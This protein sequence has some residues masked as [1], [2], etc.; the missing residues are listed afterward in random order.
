MKYDFDINSIVLGPSCSG[1]STFISNFIKNYDIN[2]TIGVDLYK[3]QL[4]HNHDFYKL[5]IWDTGK[6]LLYKNI[7]YKFLYLSNIYIIINKNQDY[8]FIKKIFDIANNN[9]KKTLEHIIIIYNKI[10]NKDTFKYNETIIKNFNNNNKIK[11]Y[12][13]YLN[14]SHKNEANKVIDNIKEYIEY[15]KYNNFDSDDDEESKLCC[16]IC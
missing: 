11:I 9:I 8:D 14:L 3:L 1:K 13:L 7:I 6:G 12:F 5:N 15:K 4:N 10:N 16:S 2:P